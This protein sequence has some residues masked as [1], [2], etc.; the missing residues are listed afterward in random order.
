MIETHAEKLLEVFLAPILK[1]KMEKLQK[2]LVRASLASAV[3]V[4]ELKKILKMFVYKAMDEFFEE[5][6]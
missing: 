1:K 3:P 2:K 4:V 6:K 5:K